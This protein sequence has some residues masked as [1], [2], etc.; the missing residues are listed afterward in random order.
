MVEP[1]RLHV[2]RHVYVCYLVLA[3]HNPARVMMGHT[4]GYIHQTC[5][6]VASLLQYA[7][8][9][10]VN[11]YIYKLDVCFNVRSIILSFIYYSLD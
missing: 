10:V 11:V 7:H 2:L 1:H 4:G 5:E 8:S 6:R 3:V 9:C